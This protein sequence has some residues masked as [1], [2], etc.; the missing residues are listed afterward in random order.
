LKKNFVL[1]LLCCFFNDISS[2][3]NVK[4]RNDPVIKGPVFFLENSR[5]VS[6]PEAQKLPELRFPD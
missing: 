2:G 6:C 1:W 5:W 4:K 3:R